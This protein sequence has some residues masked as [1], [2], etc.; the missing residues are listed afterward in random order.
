MAANTL[1]MAFG[2]ALIGD[3]TGVFAARRVR[4]RTSRCRNNH[5]D[6][7]VGVGDFAMVPGVFSAPPIPM[8]DSLRGVLTQPASW[9][10]LSMAFLPSVFLLAY[11]PAQDCARGDVD[12]K[13]PG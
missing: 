1:S 8:K 7:P 4:C 12:A 6:F 11:D 10:S 9:I 13:F 5:F 2:R 3:P